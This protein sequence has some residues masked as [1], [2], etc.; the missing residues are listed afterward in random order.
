MTTITRARAAAI[1]ALGAIA[2]TAC[3]PDDNLTPAEGKTVTISATAALPTTGMQAGGTT[4]RAISRAASPTQQSVN[5]N[6]STNINITL[7]TYSSSTKTGHAYSFTKVQSDVA[8]K[9]ELEP[10]TEADAIKAKT[11][12]SIELSIDEMKLPLQLPIVHKINDGSTITNNVPFSARAKMEKQSFTVGAEGKLDKALTLAYTTAA[13]RL[14]LEIADDGVPVSQV[15]CPNL[16]MAGDDPTINPTPA[17]T[18]GSMNANDPI[19]QQTVIFGELTPGQKIETDKILAILTISSPSSSPSDNPGTSDTKLLAVMWPAGMSITHVPAA[20]SMLTLTVHVGCTVATIDPNGISI[21]G[22]AEGGSEDITVGYQADGMQELNTDIYNANNPLWVVAGGGDD[23]QGDK[24]KDKA[25]LANV[26]AAL[27]AMKESGSIPASA[28]GK[29]DLMLTGM[30]ELPSTGGGGSGSKPGSSTA[31]G[32]FEGCT[33]LH[34][35]NL[36]AATTLRDNCFNGCTELTTISLPVATVI[37]TSSFEGCAKLTAASLPAVTVIG[38]RSFYSC[39]AMTSFS[40]PVA[41]TIGYYAFSGCKAL[42][43]LDLPAI[44]KI[45]QD[46]FNNISGLESLSLPAAT[47]ISWDLFDGCTN[48]T[49]LDISGVTDAGKISDSYN[50]TNCDGSELSGTAESADAFVT[51]ACHLVISKTLYDALAQEQIANKTFGGQTWA[52]IT[53]PGAPAAPQR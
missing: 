41:T 9:A 21:G 23:S 16:A 49:R 15:S 35:V 43:S 36:P 6:F 53:Y 14:R 51:T 39:A 40:A 18:D 1:L 20:G 38:N 24:A 44:K 22:F 2:L 19:T 7:N 3:H 32:A 31:T 37:S 12:N 13:L 26:L 45:Y 4:S 10:K 48:L 34:S 50:N 27:N 11:G 28:Q 30:T 29:I 42:K 46:A 33:Q 17:R 47:G 5:F 8:D 25:V 52:S